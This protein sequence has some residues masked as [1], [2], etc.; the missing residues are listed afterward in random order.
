MVWE[1]IPELTNTWET[2]ETHSD[3]GGCGHL[4]DCFIAYMGREGT[5]TLTITTE[6][7]SMAYTLDPVTPGQFV[8]CYRVLSPQKSKW[9]RYRLDAP[10]VGVRLYQKDS[11]IRVKE[12]GSAGPYLNSQPFGDDSRASGARM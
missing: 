6:Y 9:R 7:G 5:P 10:G 11:V 3:L 2:Q 12:W 1:P 4:R 8:R